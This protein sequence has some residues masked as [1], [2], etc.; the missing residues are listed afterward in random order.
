MPT[1]LFK[2]R[3]CNINSEHEQLLFRVTCK[4][5]SAQAGESVPSTP[6]L[7]PHPSTNVQ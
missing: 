4:E 2:K 5:E 1:S 7:Q 6:S 3:E